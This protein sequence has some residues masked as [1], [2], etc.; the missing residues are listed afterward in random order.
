MPGVPGQ[1][2]LSPQG[3]PQGQ[4]RLWPGS[5]RPAARGCGSPSTSPGLH[6]FTSLQ[7]HNSQTS[8]FERVS[9]PHCKLWYNVCCAAHKGESTGSDWFQCKVSVI[10]GSTQKTEQGTKLNPQTAVSFS[11]TEDYFLNSVCQLIQPSCTV[12]LHGQKD[13]CLLALYNSCYSVL[14]WGQSG[15]R[16]QCTQS[17]KYFI[18]TGCFNLNLHSDIYVSSELCPMSLASS[19]VILKAADNTT[20]YTIYY[21]TIWFL[22]R[23]FYCAILRHILTNIIFWFEG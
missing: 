11:G 16:I 7:K 8:L 14:L 21:A 19:A 6:G 13:N 12:K 22:Q 15:Y 5:A 23:N 2:V 3:E 4:G 18:C 9:Q 17:C 1:Q 10:N 20:P